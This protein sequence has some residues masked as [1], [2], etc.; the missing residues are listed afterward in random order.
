MSELA[1]RFQDFAN[2]LTGN[3]PT[4]LSARLKA[5][6]CDGLIKRTVTNRHLPCTLYELMELGMGAC[7]MILALRG[8]GCT[9]PPRN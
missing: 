9:L 3:S 5:L 2:A 8:F 1:R 7:H 6:R 4:T